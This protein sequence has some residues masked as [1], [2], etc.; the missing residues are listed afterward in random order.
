MYLVYV[1]FNGEISEFIGLFNDRLLAEEFCKSYDLDLY[2]DIYI[3]FVP[4]IK[5]R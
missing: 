3:K 2:D 4:I 5:N 1:Y